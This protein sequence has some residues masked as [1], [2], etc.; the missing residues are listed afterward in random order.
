[1]IDASHLEGTV[2]ATA[3]ALTAAATLAD[4]RRSTF[5]VG[6]AAAHSEALSALANVANWTFAVF[7]A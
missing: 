4:L 1:M 7:A 5:I 2:T 6:N 3:T